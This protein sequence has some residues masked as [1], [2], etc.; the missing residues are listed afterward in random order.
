MAAS[1][2]DFLA[3]GYDPTLLTS[4]DVHERYGFPLRPLRQALMRDDLDAARLWAPWLHALS[5]PD[6]PGAGGELRA[7]STALGHAG[8]REAAAR[9]RALAAERTNTSASDAVARNA[10]LLGR[11]GSIASTALMI[12]FFFLHLVLIA[13]YQRAQGLAR[14]RRIESGLRPLPLPQ[15]RAIRFYG[16]TEK[17]V[18]VVMLALAY[19]TVVLVGWVQ[20]GDP[21]VATAAAG[22]LEAPAAAAVW[23][24][25]DG[26]PAS[27]AW[28]NAYRADRAGHDELVRE[29][30][31]SLD[32]RLLDPV[33]TALA[34][35]DPVPAPS[36]VTLR[37][38]AAGTWFDF[39]ADAFVRPQLL[40]DDHLVLLGLPAWSWPAQLLLFWL[41]ALWHLAWLLIPRP[42]YAAHAPRPL[43]YE[44]LAI[45][46]PGSG[47]ADELYGVLLLVPWALFGIDTITQLLGGQSALGIPFDAGLAV[48]GVLYVVNLIAWAIEFVS[49]R[50]RLTHLR[51]A[52][53]DLARAFGLTPTDAAA[54]Q[55]LDRA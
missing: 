14:R 47:Q 33:V 22:H 48:L 43:L 39:V 28:V 18:L 1:A 20:R 16:A 3:R 32:A 13:K 35:G 34:Q 11:G 46:V 30:L 19:A 27:L 50:R 53:P 29:T 4:A 12:A 45:L 38:A 26:D 21:L 40:L 54:A 24:S 41:V 9:W 51:A 6:L 23:S 2:D 15:V 37:A 55:E 44:L 8:E 25:A 17:L 7:F 52:H 31:G 36:P 49:V 5:G 42:R 10:L